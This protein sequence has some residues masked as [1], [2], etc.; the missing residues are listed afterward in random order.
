MSRD[1]PRLDGREVAELLGVHEVSVRRWRAKGQGPAYEKLGE[2]T[3]RYRLSEIRR[4]Q[5]EQAGGDR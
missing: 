5:R 3:V 4:Y 1:D 2:R